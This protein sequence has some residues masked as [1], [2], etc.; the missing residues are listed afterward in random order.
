MHLVGIRLAVI[1]H[2]IS[3]VAD[4]IIDFIGADI[5]GVPITLTWTSVELAVPSIGPAVIKMV[6][7]DIFRRSAPRPALKAEWCS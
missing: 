1:R 2:S 5:G 7:P 3:C 6:A 4:E